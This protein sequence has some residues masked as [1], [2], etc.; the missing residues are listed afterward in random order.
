MPTEVFGQEKVERVPFASDRKKTKFVDLNGTATLRI[1]TKERTVVDTHFINASKATVKCLG[2]DCPVCANNK[3]L[4]IQF[5]KDFRDEA[6]YS[7][8]RQVKLVNV[9]DKTPL[10]TCEKC[11]HEERT[12]QTCSSCK[13]IITSE[14]KP[15]D[16][17]K[18]LSRG[19]TLFDSLD[20]IDNAVLDETGEKVGIT[21]Y[22]IT[23]L[24]SGTGK[25]K[26][27]T[28]IVGGRGEVRPVTA[29]ELFDLETITITVTPSEMVDLQRGVSLRDLFSARRASAKQEPEADP[30][31]S[32]ELLASVNDDVEAL[33]AK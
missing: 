16:T 2:E 3:N 31:V 23:L 12:S 25:N 1:L 22:D 17:V 14:L 5:P 28:P 24:V 21:N 32:K 33:F 10:R 9:L 29:E 8:R 11:G 18:V 4:I 6:L 30:F 15:S 13:E 7:A 26:T 20:A 27:I 19:V